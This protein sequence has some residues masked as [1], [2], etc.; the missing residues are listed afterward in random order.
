MA[1]MSILFPTILVAQHTEIR[2]DAS[3][4][5][6][7]TTAVLMLLSYTAYIF[8]QLVTHKNLFDAPTPPPAALAGLETGAGGDEGGEDEEEVVLGFWGGLV[9]L[10]LVTAAISSL[11]DF[12]VSAIEGAA[13]QWGVPLAFLSVIVIPIANNVTEHAAAVVFAVR[14]KVDI[15][16]GIALGS[17]TQIA[18][19]VLPLVVLVGWGQGAPLT[20]DFRVFATAVLFSATLVVAY[21]LQVTPARCARPNRP[22]GRASAPSICGPFRPAC[23]AAPRHTYLGSNCGR[24]PSR[25]ITA[26]SQLVICCVCVCLALWF[27]CLHRNVCCV[28]AGRREQLAQGAHAGDHVRRGRRRLLPAQGRAPPALRHAPLAHRPLTV[29]RAVVVGMLRCR[30]HSQERDGQVERVCCI[31]SLRVAEKSSIYSRKLC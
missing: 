31:I 18:M 12:L 8:F 16:L 22:P 3:L 21:L 26:P 23:R 10:A 5:L 13:V 15:S 1:V 9:W 30:V 7:R 24:A 2:A 4:A 25:C 27:A 29:T 28:R 6:S 17:S 19:F 11:S 20:L 14:N